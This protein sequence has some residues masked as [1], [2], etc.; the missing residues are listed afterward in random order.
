MRTAA[1]VLLAKGQ[2]MVIDDIELP[3]PGPTQVMIKQYASGVCHSQL[4]E[5]NRPSP[6]TPLVLGHESTGVVTAKGAG[7][8][9]VK[10]GD[11]VMITWVQ[12]SARAGMP[13]PAVAKV[14][15]GGTAI[16]HGAPTFTGVFTWAESTVVDEQFVVPLEAG[17]ATD[18]TS[19]VGCAV[20]T[21]CGAAMNAA[22]V[23]PGDSVAVIGAGGVGLSIIQGAAILGA[24][25]II[26]VDVS[27]DKLAFAKQF[28][29]TA[30]V[31]ASEGDPVEKVRELTGGLGVDH[32][33]DAIGLGVTTEQALMMARARVPGDRQ[34]G[35]A[36]LV[37]VPHGA[38]AALQMGA[39]FGGKVYR[40]APGGSSRPDH[41]FPTF[42]RW[43][44]EGRLPLDL[45]VTRRYRLDQINE[46]CRALAAGEVAGR[47]IIEF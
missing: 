47:A 22:E 34:G 3:D 16:N 6:A 36:V 7:V 41:D 13:Q 35:T 30:G 21:G 9:H 5:L 14:T 39:I 33:F 1:A 27:D 46:A 20:M 38:P 42:I 23:R 28:G 17:V 25:P 19:I 32:A 26:V 29:G 12:R 24:H 10:E 18:V 45:M 15:H 2:D 37:G 44:K 8:T 31:N 40:G 11:N 43:F 4:H